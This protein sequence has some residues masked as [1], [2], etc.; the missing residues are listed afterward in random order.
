MAIGP[1]PFTAIVDYFTIYSIDGDFSEFASVIRRID[2]VYLEL[3]AEK[4]K[5]EPN[6]GNTKGATTNPDKKNNNPR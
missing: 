3:N 4:M 2:D 6:K 5:S 1:I